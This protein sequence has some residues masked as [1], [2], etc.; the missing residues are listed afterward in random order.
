MENTSLGTSDQ[1][2][3]TPRTHTQKIFA[4]RYDFT[5]IQHFLSCIKSIFPRVP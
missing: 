3:L 5:K 2:K 1:F 4:F